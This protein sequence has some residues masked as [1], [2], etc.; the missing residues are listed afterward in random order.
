MP[1][2][3][4]YVHEL[5]RLPGGRRLRTRFA[6]SVTGRLHLGHLVNAVYVWGIAR[7]IDA[8][9][10]LRLEDHDRGRFRP[11]Y[12]TA[13]LD[14]LDW[15]G[16][17]PDL[18]ATAEFRAGASPWRQS[19][20]ATRYAAALAEL[21]SKGL[22]YACE[23]SRS[24][25]A[26]AGE[27]NDGEEERRY[28]GTCRD[29]GLPE[30]A[31]RRIRVRIEPG[32][33]R[34]DDVRLGPQ[35]QDPSA[36]CGDLVARDVQGDWT[37]QFAVAVDDLDQDITL[38]IRGLDLLGSTGRQ[39]R[40]ARLLG[41]RDPSRYLHHP[42]VTDGAGRKLSKR[43]FARSLADHRAEGRTAESLLGEA[44]YLGGL[45][46]EARPVPVKDLPELF[47]DIATS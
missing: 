40:L 39:L 13:I 46:P 5:R 47:A 32:I 1:V 34:F 3:L 9:V 22:T 27:Q 15:L 44:A 29:K 23:C 21:R 43:D 41:R 38:V 2:P 37:Y 25:L 31:G 33:E 11:E 20:R 42:L 35:E 24:A 28:P 16:L 45:L 17:T 4:P 7:A 26:H 6:P 12:E 19:D 30:A 18:G 10:A 36:Q 14:D 8:E